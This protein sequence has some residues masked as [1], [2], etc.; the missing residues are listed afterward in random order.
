M[1]IFGRI[2]QSAWTSRNQDRLPG[3]D[4]RDMVDLPGWEQQSIWGWDHAGSFFAQLWRNGNRGDEPDLWLSG[5]S[6]HYSQASCIVVEI[7][8]KLGADP[9]AVVTALGLADPKP[10]LRP[11]DQV[12][13]L[14]RPGVN[15]QGKTRL[16][17]GAIHALGWAQGLVARTP[18]SNH[19]WPGPRPTAD[20][21]VA[22]HHLVTGRLHLSGGDR[23]F[24]AGVDA[25]LWWY[26]RHSDDTWFL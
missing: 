6:T 13:E 5:I 2:R 21:V 8:D 26:L 7:V 16:D 15:K 14:L 3:D 1:G 12:M 10:R 22:E 23:D 9:A 24:L 25:A 19:P 17:Q 20:R 18:V 11:D 4:F